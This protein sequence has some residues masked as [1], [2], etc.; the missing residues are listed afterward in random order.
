MDNA[1]PDQWLALAQTHRNQID[2]SI[3]EHWVF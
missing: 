1:Q 2:L 3:L